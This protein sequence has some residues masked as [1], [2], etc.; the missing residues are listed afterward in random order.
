MQFFKITCPFAQLANFIALMQVLSGQ[1]E[2]A[3][4]L[5]NA[6]ASA[7]WFLRTGY[8]FTSF[9]PTLNEQYG[10]KYREFQSAQEAESELD[11]AEWQQGLQFTN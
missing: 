2:T 11:G 3:F 7:T 10:V 6:D 4:M 8:N 5:V 9:L 1:I